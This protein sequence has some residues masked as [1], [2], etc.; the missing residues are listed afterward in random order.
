MAEVKLV[1]QQERQVWSNE[2]WAE[3]IRESAFAPYM[4][5]GPTSIIRMLR[6]LEGRAGNAVN[7]PLTGRLK[8]RGVRGSEVLEGNEQDM[9]TFN[10][11]VYIDWHRDGVVVPKSTSFRTELDLLGE[12][13]PMLRSLFAEVLRDDVIR[14]LHSVVLPGAASAV[15]YDADTT[16][17]YSLSTPTQR[18]A[19][20]AANTD[21]IL[22]GIAPSNSSSGVWATSLGNVDAVNDKLTA[23][24]GRQAKR[25]ARSADPHIRPFRSEDSGRE[26]FV[27]FCNGRA[28]RD[29]E[30]DPEMIQA[31]LN[32]RAREGAGM[33]RNPIFQ[34]GDLL[35]NGIIYREVPEMGVIAGAGAG[36]IDVAINVLCG[37]GAIALAYGQQPTPRTDPDR[38][39]GFRPGVG[40]EELRGLKKVSWA[41]KQYGCV[42]VVTAAVADA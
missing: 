7:I 32:G 10:D 16:V 29:L 2:I 26:Y 8:G 24:V 41:G 20:L 15:G 39:Y 11:R 33:D 12:A 6:D 9:A 19:Y 22:F 28:F 40:L 5:R 38:D 3:Y 27:M 35:L 34:D 23:A 31:N 4:G 30:A 13:K 25:L 36:G 42:S 1:T 21:R 14:E 17:S 18:N 37:Q